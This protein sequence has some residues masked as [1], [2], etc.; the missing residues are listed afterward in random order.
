MSRFLVRV[1]FCVLDLTIY[2]S[3]NFQWHILYYRTIC[4]DNQVCYYYL[5][6]FIQNYSELAANN[7]RKIVLDLIEA[8]LSSIQPQKVMSEN[9]V[10]DTNLLTIKDKKIDLRNYERIFLIGFGK[11]SAAISKIIEET[12]KEKLTKGFVID[13]TENNFKK[14]EFTLGTHPLP[15][16][17]NLD[18]TQKVIENMQDLTEKDLVLIVIC[19]GG[20]VMLESPFNIALEK[21][22][23]VNKALLQSGADIFEMNT[24]RKH[25]SKIKGGGLA[26]ILHPAKVTALIFSDI[27]GNDLSFIA[28][29]PTVKDKTTVIDAMNIYKK[30]NLQRLELSDLDFTETPKENSVF[31]NIENILILS[32][33]TALNAMKQKAEELNISAEVFSDKFQSEANLA[34]KALIEKTPKNSILLVGGETTAHVNNPKGQG[35]RNQ[36]LVLASLFSLDKDTTI[37]AFDTDGFDNS[38]VCGAISDLQTLEKAKNLGLNPEEF[39]E[40]DNSLV[41]FKN[42]RDAIVTGRLSSN[43]SDLIIVYK[44][45]D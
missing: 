9:F 14:I 25:L 17:E 16:R 34:G 11:G 6:G 39:L 8:A 5:M 20:S 23:E 35:G 10:L 21:L 45:N 38:S 12:L 37:A 40:Q 41:F 30:Y 31:T 36:A 44:N 2:I 18:F 33:L 19:G 26:K 4:V 32:N 27:P 22:I 29:G 24:L 3:I 43:V 15:S 7:S 13:A 1:E 42:L 28:S